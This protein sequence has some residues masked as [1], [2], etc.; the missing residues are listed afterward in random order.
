[1]LNI[2]WNQFLPSSLKPLSCHPSI[3][4]TCNYCSLVVKSSTTIITSS[5]N[6]LLHDWQH[7]APW[8]INKA[9]KYPCNHYDRCL[10]M[11]VVNVHFGAITNFFLIILYLLSV[12]NQTKHPSWQYYSSQQHSAMISV[13]VEITKVYRHVFMSQ[14][15]FVNDLLT[16]GCH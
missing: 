6:M 15:L 3:V 14:D 13:Y 5:K 10:N 2:F 4:C 16:R 8:Y 7:K 1:M 12:H 11:V 9:N